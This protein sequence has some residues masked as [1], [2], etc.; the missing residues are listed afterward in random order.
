MYNVETAPHTYTSWFWA[1]QPASASVRGTSELCA[2]KPGYPLVVLFFALTHVDV[3][4][5]IKDE[6]KMNPRLK[7][8]PK[9]MKLLRNQ[10][11][12]FGTLVSLKMF[13]MWSQKHRNKCRRPTNRITA[14]PKVSEQQAANRVQR[15]PAEWEKTFAIYVNRKLISRTYEDLIQL[16]RENLF[17][18]WVNNPDGPF[19]KR[20]TLSIVCAYFRAGVLRSGDNL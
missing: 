16:D 3:S 10:E 17:L 5:H 20:C 2:G 14:N 8:K 9:T 13:W 1:R 19:L 15:Q 11:K 7:H 4:Y 12:Y 18:K 6:F